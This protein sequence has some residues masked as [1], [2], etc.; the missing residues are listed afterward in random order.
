MRLRCMSIL[1]A[2]TI[3]RAWQCSEEKKK[4]DNKRHLL[5]IKIRERTGVYS[6]RLEWEETNAT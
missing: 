4:L 2:D 5:L 3:E 1:E 6:H